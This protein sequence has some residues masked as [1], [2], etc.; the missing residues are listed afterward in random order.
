MKVFWVW[1]IGSPA[2]AQ[3][4]ELLAPS[5]GV[6]DIEL[7]KARKE[8]HRIE[9]AILIV[10]SQVENHP[11]LLKGGKATARRILSNVEVQELENAIAKIEQDISKF[12][13]VTKMLLE[14]VAEIK[15]TTR[16]LLHQLGAS[17]SLQNLL[18]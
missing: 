13:T 17:R 5:M 12:S 4:R 16:Q 2:F 18:L 11:L 10:K 15:E 14:D 6:S 7:Q 9:K 1:E 8:A 3:L